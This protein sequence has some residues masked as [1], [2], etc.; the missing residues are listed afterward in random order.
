MLIAG[1]ILVLGA[2]SALGAA[3][4]FSMRDRMA[5]RF[6]QL[7]DRF[8]LL[9]ESLRRGFAEQD[10]RLA[11]EAAALRESGG[12]IERAVSVE[13]GRTLSRVIRTERVYAEL[14]EEQKKKTLD[15]LYGEEELLARGRRAGELFGAGKYK[16]AQELYA[17]LS[18]VQP[19]NMEVRFYRYYS[20]FMMNK[21]DRNQY[22]L[23]REGL[24]QL[25]RSGYMRSEIGETLSY[26]AAEEMLS[27]TLQE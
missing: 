27:T 4:F 10:R 5:R 16:Q 20:L 9:E 21:N 25:E 3:A 22:R 2:V 11:E 24:M 15:A 8:N 12:R 26:I 1:L 14:L 18:E 7:E 19:E 17:G 13:T 23:I 6:D